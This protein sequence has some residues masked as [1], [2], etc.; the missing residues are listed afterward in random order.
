MQT[1]S[2]KDVASRDRVA[3]WEQWNQASLVGLRCFTPEPEQFEAQAWQVDVSGAVV[4]RIQGRPHVIDRNSAA[5]DSTPKNSVFISTLLR[6][7]AFLYDAGGLHILHPG[8]T[9]VYSTM[10]PY[11]LGFERDMD[12]LIVDVDSSVAESEW[13]RAIGPTPQINA[14]TDASRRVAAQGR[15]MLSEHVTSQGLETDAARLA[16]LCR[17]L[18]AQDAPEQALLA[19]ARTV[20]ERRFT[21]PDFDSAALARELDVSDRHLRRV[22]AQ[23]GE[24]PGQAILSVRLK[25]ARRRLASDH[26]VSVAD[27]ALACGF[28]TPSSFARAFKARYGM[29]PSQA[30][31]I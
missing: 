12:L 6:G 24:G 20:I 16:V 14:A 28:G 26:S 2:T 29:S 15:R 21:D 11:L 3:Y 18:L 19:R 9:L 4:T 31:R 25:A 22:F 27:I 17:D 13:G 8:D 5:I 30:R 1:I 23:N 10:H 7:S